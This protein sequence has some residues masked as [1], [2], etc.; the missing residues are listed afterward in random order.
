MSK[1]KLL[2][3]TGHLFFLIYFLF[4]VFYAKERVLFVDSAYQFFKIIN[5]EDFNIE[6]GRFSAV[7]T[8]IPLLTA[9][10]LHLPLNWLL[11]IF[12]LSFPLLY[13]LIYLI[14]VYLF[15]Q[16]AAGILLCLSLCITIR[17]SFFHVVTETH[18]A[19]AYSCLFFAWL[20]STSIKTSQFKKIL[21]GS[22]ILVLALFSHPVAYLTLIFVLLFYLGDKQGFDKKLIGIISVFIFGVVV[23]KYLNTPTGTYEGQFLS[24]VSYFHELIFHIDTFASKSFYD[25]FYNRLY[26]LPF[27]MIMLVSIYYLFKLNFK[28]LI[29]VPI[30]YFGFLTFTLL[31]YNKGDSQIMMERAFMPL[32]FFAGLP[33]VY[34]ILSKGDRL[35]WFKTVIIIAMLTYGMNWIYRTANY[36]TDRI[37]YMGQFISYMN[38]SKIDKLLI[39]G[40]DTSKRIIYIP[41]AFGVETLI[42]SSLKSPEFSKTVYVHD[43]PK[44]ID[45]SSPDLLLLVHFDQNNDVKLLNEKYFKLPATTYKLLD[46]PFKYSE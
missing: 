23:F 13:Y 35:K 44:E 21:T 33:L 10:K 19:I 36:F 5:F 29:I 12:S 9:V 11:L 28:K 34:D 1:N 46:R 2:V 14:S 41:W 31:I 39:G 30:A 15:K 20:N 40:D 8:Q 25:Q 16:P 32:A 43:N 38:D 42:Y 17:H 18:Q 26:R 3:L 7:I 37:E 6:A 45:C 27:Y 24:Q 22:V 4:A